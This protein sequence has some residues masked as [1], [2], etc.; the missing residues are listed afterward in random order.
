MTNNYGF[1]A[2]MTPQEYVNWESNLTEEQIADYQL[3]IYKSYLIDGKVLECEDGS[4]WRLFDI[5]KELVQDHFVRVMPKHK[6]VF[7]NKKAKKM[8]KNDEK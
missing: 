8:E 2:K 4:R 1:V 6:E 3:Y 7:F 5:T